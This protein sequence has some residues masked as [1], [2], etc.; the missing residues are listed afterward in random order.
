MLLCHLMARSEKE[1]K[2]SG[3]FDSAQF[4]VLHFKDY[5]AKPVQLVRSDADIKDVVN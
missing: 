2:F 4:L 5:S 3:T 1:G